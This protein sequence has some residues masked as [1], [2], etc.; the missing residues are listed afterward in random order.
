MEYM[1]NYYNY[2]RH[3]VTMLAQTTCSIRSIWVKWNASWMALLNF[4]FLKL[5]T[6]EQRPKVY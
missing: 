4:H 3:E 1:S 2:L 5:T 6:A